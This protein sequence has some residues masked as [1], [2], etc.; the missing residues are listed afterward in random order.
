MLTRRHTLTAVVVLTAVLAGCQPADVG[1]AAPTAAR[2]LAPAGSPETVSPAASPS[3][4]GSPSAAALPSA[5]A[6][7]AASAAPGDDLVSLVPATINDVPVTVAQIDPA[8]LIGSEDALHLQPVL[9]ALGKTP[10][11]IEV[12][13]GGGGAGSHSVI[14]QAVRIGGTDASASTTQLQGALSGLPNS[15]VEP[16]MV[17]GKDVLS[18][19]GDRYVY[20]SDDVVFFVS[21]SND[22]M[23]QATL[24]V[25]P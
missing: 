10:A 17:G 23:A 20:V 5:S 2:S 14:I 6:A 4:A 19:G 3:A 8:S 25:L 9:Q 18:L 24:E 13:A 16:A 7:S 11:D 12:I 1:S 21:A 15:P 22:E